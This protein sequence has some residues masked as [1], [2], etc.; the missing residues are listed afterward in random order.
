MRARPT[1]VS[2]LNSGLLPH[3]ADVAQ[4]LG[5]DEF[6]GEVN[7][8]CVPGQEGGRAQADLSRL[9]VPTARMPQNRMLTMPPGQSQN[10]CVLQL[11]PGKSG[12]TGC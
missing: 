2:L 12:G 5:I 8:S 9:S 3:P 4:Q 6:Q 1:S 10:S 11:L 7:N